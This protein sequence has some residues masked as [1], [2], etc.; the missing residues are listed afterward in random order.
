MVFINGEWHQ[1]SNIDDAMKIVEENLGGEFKDKLSDLIAK[2]KT[3]LHENYE[4][5]LGE[6][7]Y[8]RKELTKIKSRIIK[9]LS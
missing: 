1:V 6:I 9:I 8:I 5:A 3:N 7:D 4:E 2:D